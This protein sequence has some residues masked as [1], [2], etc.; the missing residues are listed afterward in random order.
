MANSELL[1]AWLFRP[2]ESREAVLQ[3]LHDMAEGWSQAADT[4]ETRDDAET[5]KV[6]VQI[7]AQIAG[8]RRSV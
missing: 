3:E 6:A 8:Q 4:E 1:Q 5:L 7:L 2:Q